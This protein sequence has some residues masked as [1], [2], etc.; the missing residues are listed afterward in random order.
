MTRVATTAI[1]LTHCL[2]RRPIKTPA[3]RAGLRSVLGGGTDSPRSFPT[4]GHRPRKKSAD[5]RPPGPIACHD[6]RRSGMEFLHGGGSCREALCSNR[7]SWRR[8][9]LACRASRPGSGLDRLH[10]LA[11]QSAPESGRRS[12]LQ[13]PRHDG[14]YLY[15]KEQ[16]IVPQIQG[17]FYRNYYGGTRK[18]GMHHYA[19]ALHPWYKR[20]FY[21]GHHYI[22]DVF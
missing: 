1:T 10:A 8:P 2:I 4:T 15:P 3:N 5:V 6:H 19:E 9:C 18:A 7:S 12:R 13:G 22:L 17:P 21:Q 16:R 11:V 20:K 14:W